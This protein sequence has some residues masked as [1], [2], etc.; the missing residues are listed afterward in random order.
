MDLRRSLGVPGRAHDAPEHEF[1]SPRLSPSGFV[2]GR[3]V[4]RVRHGAI[5]EFQ[6]MT[7][8][9]PLI[10]LESNDEND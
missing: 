4:A 5:L 2:H 1:P 6:Q 3:D 8:I 9:N 10:W 7:T